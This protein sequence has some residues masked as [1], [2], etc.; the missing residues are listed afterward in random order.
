V[1]SSKSAFKRAPDPDAEYKD[2]ARKD[3]NRALRTC[4]GNVTVCGINFPRKYLDSNYNDVLEQA[5]TALKKQAADEKEAAKTALMNEKADEGLE[6]ISEDELD[7]L[8]GGDPE[9]EPVDVP[10]AAHAEA[11]IV[12]REI[13]DSDLDALFDEDAE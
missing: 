4:G 2:V 10:E 7:S 8:F 12:S 9:Q 6:N 13:S 1:A 3:I 5:V 11:S